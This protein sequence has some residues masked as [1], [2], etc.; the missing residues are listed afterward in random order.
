M[1]AGNEGIFDR[2]KE[3]AEKVTDKVKDLFSGHGDKAD[4]AIEKTGNFVDDKTGD[5]YSEHV[6]K[7]QDAAH[8]AADELSGEGDKGGDAAK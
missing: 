6:D 1:P 2:V 8:D 4:D 5:K 7:A 3:A